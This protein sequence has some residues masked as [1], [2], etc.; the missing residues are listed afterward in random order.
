VGS[1]RR[2]LFVLLFVGLLLVISGLVIANNSTKLGL[3]LK[4]GLELV[5]EGQPTGQVEE[6]SGEDI[7]RAIEIIRQRIDELG[8]S[9]PEVS[10]LGSTEISVSLPDV[11]DARAAVEQ[12][13]TTAQL[14]FYD[15]EPNLLGPEKAIAGRPGQPNQKA[16][17]E[18]QKRWRE[19]GRNP[20][21][22]ENEVLIFA[23]AYPTAYEAALLASEQEPVQNCENCSANQ[24]RFYLFDK[25]EPHAMLAGP[26][27]RKQDLYL[28]PTGE[29]R[30]KDGLVVEVPVGTIVVSELPTNREGEALSED[31]ADPGWYAIKDDPALSGT[32]ITDP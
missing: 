28:S 24:P 17:E 32:D 27:I 2:H 16:V 11:T 22:Y 25:D 20:N 29:K 26:E 21:K 12:V 13:G 9:E 5:Y 8:V 15:W 7:E 18:S 30:P 19:A 1:R 31:E 4:G 3:D 6:V 23:G 10:R 14:Y